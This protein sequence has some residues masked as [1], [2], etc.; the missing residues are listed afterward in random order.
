MNSPGAESRPRSS[1]ALSASLASWTAVL[2]MVASSK[3][4]PAATGLL[5]L[6]LLED[7]LELLQGGDARLTYFAIGLIDYNSAGAGTLYGLGSHS[8]LRLSHASPPLLTSTN[9]LP[10]LHPSPCQAV[11]GRLL[12]LRPS[13]SW[14]PL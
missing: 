12:I 10:S 11:A 8:R 3:L 1:L 2:M 13:A 4:P 7:M 5:G 9:P 14:T 6:L